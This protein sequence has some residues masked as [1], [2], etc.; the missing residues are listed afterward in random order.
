[1]AKKGIAKKIRKGI[2]RILTAIG[3]YLKGSWV[4]L[5]LVRWPNRRSTWSMTVAVIAFTGAFITLIILLDI[6][7]KEL[8]KLIIR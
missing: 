1:M 3:G 6:G 5:R 7:F 4:E 8:F 2:L